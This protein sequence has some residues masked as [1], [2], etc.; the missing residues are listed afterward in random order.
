MPRGSQS[1]QPTADLLLR[2]ALL[3]AGPSWAMEISYITLTARLKT[4]HAY[5]LPAQSIV[6][7]S[8]KRRFFLNTLG[9]Y[10]KIGVP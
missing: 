4:I 9:R 5:S 6:L 7:F 3:V 1:L 2:D 8:Q 10:L